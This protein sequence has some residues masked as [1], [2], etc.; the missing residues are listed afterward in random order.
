MLV[1]LGRLKLF[2]F[3]YIAHVW[4]HHCFLVTL[5]LSE[6]DEDPEDFDQTECHEEVKEVWER[7]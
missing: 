4:L 3:K 6:K 2:W 1:L 7:G 5:Q